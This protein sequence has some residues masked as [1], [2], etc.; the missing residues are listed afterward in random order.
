MGTLPKRLKSIDI[1][2]AVTMLLMIFVNDVSSVKQVSGWIEHAGGNED[3]LG[4]ADVIF[5]AF[6]FIVGLSLPFAITNRLQKGESFLSVSL[7]IISRSFALLVMGFF[8]VNFENYSGAAL[9]PLS[10]FTILATVSFFLIWLDYSPQTSATK[11]N[12]C[13][14]LGAALLIVLTILYRGGDPQSPSGMLP[15]WWGIL[16]IIGWAY[17]LC[18]FLFLIA[19][20]NLKVLLAVAIVFLLINIFEH[21]EIFTTR[22]LLVDDGSS[23]ALVMLGVIT[24]L[25][26]GRLSGKGNDGVIWSVFISAGLLLIAGGLFLR[27]LTEGISKIHSTPAWVCICAGLSLL[28][29]TFLIWLADV[30]NKQQWFHIIRP[31]GTST[32]TCYLVPYF[33]YALYSLVHFSYPDIFNYG[34]GGIIRSFVVAF[35]VILVAGFMERKRLRI[36]I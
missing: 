28:V 17:L 13:R 30:K 21:S 5:P 36:K 11:K 16:G 14:A 29:F 32:L 18:A 1:L 2:R 9:L 27:P 7:Y 35:A 19:K 4:F 34:Y 25:A 20:G 15:L 8:Q 23:A 31:A 3:R 33:L 26:Y 12:I 10:V 22:L 24:A 6:L